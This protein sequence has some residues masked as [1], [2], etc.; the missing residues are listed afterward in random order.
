M[1]VA[2]EINTICVTQVAVKRKWKLRVT[3]DG[4]ITILKYNYLLHFLKSSKLLHLLPGESNVILFEISK[5][6]ENKE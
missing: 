1:N 6:S 3:F 4:V 2:I 5:V